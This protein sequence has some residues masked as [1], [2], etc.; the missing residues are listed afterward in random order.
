MRE[1][2]DDSGTAFRTQ[3]LQHY[4]EPRDTL[5][6]IEFAVERGQHLE[7]LLRRSLIDINAA[8]V[9]TL[10]HRMLLHEIVRD[11]VE[12]VDGI[13]NRLLVADAQHP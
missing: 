3:L 11:C 9:P 10:E 12:V 4:V 13:A 7:L 5:S 2:Q 8:R 1:T 6:R